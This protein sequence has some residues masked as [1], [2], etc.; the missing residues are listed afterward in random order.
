M[1]HHNQA[2]GFG[3]AG[4]ANCARKWFAISH[5][6]LAFRLPLEEVQVLEAIEMKNR[7]FQIFGKSALP[8]LIAGMILA[9]GS[10]VCAMAEGHGGGH[11]G[12]RSFS[13]SARGFSGGG[14]DYHGGRDYDRGRDYR[15][16]GY[17]RGG[18]FS[19]G[20]GVPYSYPYYSYGYAPA[21]APCGY[22]DRLGYWHANPACYNGT[23]G[24]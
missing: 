11:S 4:F 16:G 12:G 21:P 13:G 20:Y 22:Y 5:L 23:L 6:N 19:F 3:H 24:Y 1:A 10:P 7:L 18:G 17:Y 14:R 2:G 15:G 9:F 8:T